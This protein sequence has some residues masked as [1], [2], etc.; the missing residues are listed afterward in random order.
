[1]LITSAVPAFVVLINVS[2]MGVTLLFEWITPVLIISIKGRVSFRLATLLP[3]LACGGCVVV[4]AEPSSAPTVSPSCCNNGGR[5]SG[6]I[7]PVTY[8]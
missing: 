2:P 3:P 4:L 1:M 7:P 5:F 8:P 6:C